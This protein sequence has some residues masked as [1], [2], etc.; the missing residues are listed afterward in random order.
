MQF[1]ARIE[2]KTL[3]AVIVELDRL[4]FTHMNFFLIAGP[5]Q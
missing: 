3:I 4:L 2:S 5:L 1:S